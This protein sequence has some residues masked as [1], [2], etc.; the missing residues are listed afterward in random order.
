MKQMSPLAVV[1]RR[2]ERS[3]GNRATIIENGMSGTIWSSMYQ[4]G[5]LV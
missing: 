1:Q 2:A 4:S 3:G 5:A